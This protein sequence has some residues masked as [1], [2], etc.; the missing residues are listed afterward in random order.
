MLPNNKSCIQKIHPTNRL[1]EECVTN[2]D[3]SSKK[4]KNL[5]ALGGSTK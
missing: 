1:L 5:L 2:P 4:M 3:S